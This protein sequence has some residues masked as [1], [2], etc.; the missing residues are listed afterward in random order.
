MLQYLRYLAISFILVLLIA[1]SISYL[2]DPFGYFRI[3]GFRAVSYLGDRV[4]G[5]DRTVKPLV[6]PAIRADT[7]LLGTSRV[8]IG[9]DVDDPD[10]REYLGTS[11]NLSLAGGTID[12]LDKLTRYAMNYHVPSNIIIGLDFGRFVAANRASIPEFVNHDSS[13][14][15]C[16]IGMLRRVGFALWSKDTLMN[17]VGSLFRNHSAYLNGTRNIA[18]NKRKLKRIGARVQSQEIERLIA[19]RLDRNRNTSTYAESMTTLDRLVGYACSKNVR[20]KLFISPL[21]V[22]Q[23]LLLN[24]LNFQERYFGW[25]RE[26]VNISGQHRLDGCGVDLVDFSRITRFTTDPFPSID[27]LKAL[28]QWYLDSSHYNNLLGKFIIYR[29]WGSVH[30]PHDFGINLDS[31]VIESQIDASR[32]ELIQ[33]QHAHPDL[34]KELRDVVL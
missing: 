15:G 1:G 27:N 14:M 12:E 11:Y 26:L 3:N 19:R 18:I 8:K 7:L 31:E 23:L 6:L 5:G 33:Y 25:K 29:L 30:A 9:F 24:T 17:A 32:E 28:P 16:F 20:V 34:V 21:H 22:R 4:W 13:L 10:V 2:L